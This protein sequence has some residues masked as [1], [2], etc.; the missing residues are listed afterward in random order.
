MTTLLNTEVSEIKVAKAIAAILEE[1]GEPQNQL[2][3]KAIGAFDAGHH[4]VVKR[5]AATNLADH[6]CKCLGYLGGALKLTPNTDTIL[7]EAARSAAEFSKERALA[8]LGAAIDEAL[9]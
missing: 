1:L 5:L 8:R 2:H 3:H 9:N 6:Y 4:Q 7:A